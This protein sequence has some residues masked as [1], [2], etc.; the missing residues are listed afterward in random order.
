MTFTNN[1]GVLMSA[2]FPLN[3][4]TGDQFRS[5]MIDITNTPQTIKIKGFSSDQELFNTVMAGNFVQIGKGSTPSL[6]TDFNIESPFTNGGVEDNQIPTGVGGFTDG[7][8]K[9]LYTTQ[10]NPTAGSGSIREV[11]YFLTLRNSSAINKTFLMMRD[12]I[13]LIGFIA[14]QSITIENEVFI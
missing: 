4:G 10:I 13:P 7:N 6:R 14:G 2:I 8:N 11:C 9:I 3:S 5:G 1:M 12:I